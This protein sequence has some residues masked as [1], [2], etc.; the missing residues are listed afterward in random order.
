MKIRVY[1]GFDYKS[2]LAVNAVRE[3]AVILAAEYAVKVDVEILEFP[4]GDGE[5]GEL[6]LPEVW[7]GD[8]IIA[9]G[10]APSI[11]AIVDAAFNGLEKDFSETGL[12]LPPLANKEGEESLLS[13]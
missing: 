12:Q 3:A 1:A 5:S 9:R 2:R 8:R 11:A 7:V 10:E 13:V 4:F 6:G